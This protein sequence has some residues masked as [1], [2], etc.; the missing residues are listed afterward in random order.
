MFFMDGERTVYLMTF[1]SGIAFVILG[2]SMIAPWIL[3]SG[4]ICRRSMEMLLYEQTMASKAL[5][6]S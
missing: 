1:F 5:T 6:P 3:S 2:A 4:M